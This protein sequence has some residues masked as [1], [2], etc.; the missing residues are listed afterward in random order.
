MAV[1]EVWKFFYLH[2]KGAWIIYIKHW[3]FKEGYSSSLNGLYANTGERGVLKVM[4]VALW[5]RSSVCSIDSGTGS[6][7]SALFPSVY[8]KYPDLVL[9]LIKVP[10]DEVMSCEKMLKVSDKM[11]IWK[12]LMKNTFEPY[13]KTGRFFVEVSFAGSFNRVPATQNTLEY[14]SIPTISCSFQE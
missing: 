1:L 8:T 10:D 2:F 13:C 9:N 4:M 3:L 12:E 11:K 7:W 6:T 14:I 5:I